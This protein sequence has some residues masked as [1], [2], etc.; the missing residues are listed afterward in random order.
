MKTSL[1]VAAVAFCIAATP[2]SAAPRRAVAP[3]SAALSMEFVHLPAA[4]GSLMSTGPDAWVD[5]NTVGQQAGSLGKTLR[6][7]RQFGLRIHRAGGVA[8]GSARVTARLSTPDG[9][10]SVRVDGQL[11]GSTPVVVNARAAV[12][13]LTIHTIEI[14]ISDAVPQGP[15]S[16]SISWEALSQ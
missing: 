15:L 13:G 9:R 10:S 14:E 3:R 6:V 5:F 16:A 4:E 11:L 1:K 2:L 7:R 8:S 12:G